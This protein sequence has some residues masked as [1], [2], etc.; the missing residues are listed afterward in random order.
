METGDEAL[1]RP[2]GIGRAN[3]SGKLRRG[4]W[5]NPAMNW[6]CMADRR[7]KHARC[8]WNSLISASPRA[9]LHP[10]HS[11]QGCAS[12]NASR[13]SA[14]RGQLADTAKRDP[15]VLPGKALDGGGGAVV[16]V[17]EKCR[18]KSGD[19]Q[20]LRVLDRGPSVLA[21]ADAE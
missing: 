2:H 16:G 20:R 18:R 15:G 19:R 3:P 17:A 4:H 5:V 13:C 14:E 6:T 8:W 11:R 7:G 21:R 10:H 12:K 9:A 1:L